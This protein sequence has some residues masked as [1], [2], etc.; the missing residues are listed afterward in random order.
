[1]TRKYA[2]LILIVLEYPIVLLA[3]KIA[4]TTLAGLGLE[5]PFIFLFVAFNLIMIILGIFRWEK[6]QLPKMIILASVISFFLF[7]H[8]WNQRT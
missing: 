1:M 7:W 2:F 6:G 3:Q 4:P 5:I 8:L